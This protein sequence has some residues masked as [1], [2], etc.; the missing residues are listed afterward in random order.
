[1]FQ[2]YG[3][4]L[5]VTGC[6]ELVCGIHW[7]TGSTRGHSQGVRQAGQLGVYMLC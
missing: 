2:K 1:M 6:L 5:L 7:D 4:A 3:S